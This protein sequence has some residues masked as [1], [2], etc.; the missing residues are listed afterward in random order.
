V[1]ESVTSFFCRNGVDF[2]EFSVHFRQCRYETLFSPASFAQAIAEGGG[3]GS[4]QLER[5]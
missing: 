5:S 2:R 1:L 3:Q 4:V